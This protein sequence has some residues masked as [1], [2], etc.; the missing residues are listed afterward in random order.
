M[1]G[2]SSKTTLI[3]LRLPNEVVCTLERRINGRRTHWFG[4]R[5]Y[6]QERIIYDTQREHKRRPSK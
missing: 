1:S 5:E 2:T 4:V 6:L 3:T